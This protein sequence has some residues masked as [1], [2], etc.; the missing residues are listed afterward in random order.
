MAHWRSGAGRDAFVSLSTRARVTYRIVMLIVCC[1][2][3]LAFGIARGFLGYPETLSAA[4]P[5]N[6]KMLVDP[7]LKLV[8]QQSPYMRNER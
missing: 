5:F 4:P 7:A 3:I 1:S 8:S 2:G 6:Q